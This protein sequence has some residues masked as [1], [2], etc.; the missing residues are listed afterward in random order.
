MGAS[1][2]VGR[3]GGLAVALGLGA[4]VF[5]GHGVASAA[6]DTESSAETSESVGSA[7]TDDRG[8]VQP[9]TSSSAAG[10]HR[11]PDS[12]D[13]AQDASRAG[14]PDAETP[15]TPQAKPAARSSSSRGRLEARA[16]RLAEADPSTATPEMSSPHQSIPSEVSSETAVASTAEVV[17]TPVP[18]VTVDVADGAPP[19]PSEDEPQTPDTPGA[20]WTL[21]A[22]AHRESVVKRQAVVLP[23]PVAV[24][25]GPPSVQDDADSVSDTAVVDLPPMPVTEGS[26][27]TVSTD[28]MEGFVADYLARGG[29]PTD[30]ARFFFGDLAV[31][32]LDALVN[33]NVQPEEARL[34]LG[35]LTASGYFGGLW[36]RDSLRD[37]AT[38]ADTPAPADDSRDERPLDEAAT[39]TLAPAAIAIRL[40]DALATFL[41]KAAAG[42]HPWVVRTVA[43][44]AVP[45][46]LFLYGYNR[47]YLEFVLENP[48]P[49][50]PSRKD[51]LTC[52]G[53][54]DCNSTAFPLELATRYDSALDRLDAPAT[55]RWGEMAVWTKFIEGAAG[56]GRS[57][58]KVI[59]G[60][61]GGF[62][63][64]TYNALVDLS[65][66][67]LMVTKAATLSSMLAYADRD[68]DLGRSS[69]RLQS[70]LWMWVGSYFA[71]LI[72]AAPAGTMPESVAS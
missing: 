48:P 6:P 1:S 10:D 9:S 13:D 33:P 69:L 53:F 49:G 15:E 37:N 38:G 36:L 42:K 63:P 11:S 29:D 26:S 70:G 14:S 41:N 64:T 62:S 23:G 61:T 2:Y 30:N 46:Q 17:P 55:L 35:N 47:G 31:A 51:S 65:S 43:R 67:F 7:S 22:G 71:G 50:V 54:L 21:L 32:S 68:V 19:G 66:A 58:W 27:F 24:A 57:V 52:A 20:V 45:V 3:V 16:S 72:S 59:T 56:V 18:M 60:L 39:A 44:I 34:L 25:E 40:F 5:S 4:V 28:F 12:S 8:T